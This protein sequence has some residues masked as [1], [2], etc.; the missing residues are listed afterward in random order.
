[1]LSFFRPFYNVTCTNSSSLYVTS[2]EYCQQICQVNEQLEEMCD[3]FEKN[4][5]FVVCFSCS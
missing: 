1:M 4:Q 2:N 3:R 5:Y